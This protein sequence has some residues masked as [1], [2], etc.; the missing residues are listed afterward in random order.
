MLA[1]ALIAL[2]CALAVPALAAAET[3]VVNSAAD[4]EDAA[5]GDEYCKDAD[6]ECTLRAAI[7]E[8]NALGG[9]SAFEFSEAVFNGGPGATISLG[10]SLPTI[11]VT[12]T[13]DGECSVAEELQPCVG[14]DGPS[15]SNPALV[16]KGVEATIIGLAITG[17]KVGIE[18]TGGSKFTARQDWFG[19]KLDGSPGPNGTG[20]LLGPGLDGGRIGNEGVTNVFANST[21]DGLDIHG[22]SNVRVMSGY[23][24]VGPD[25]TAPAPNAGK[26]IEV[27]SFEGVEAIGN[28]IGTQ[29]EAREAASAKCDGGC[30]VISLA[31]KSGIDLEGDGGEEFPAVSTSIV[32]NYVGLDATGAVAIPNADDNVR[33][34]SA[35]RTTIGG[36]RAGEANYFAGGDAAVHA[37]PAASS[38][39]VRGNSVGL[40]AAGG[41]VPPPDAGIV[42]DSTQVPD[43]AAEPMVVENAL[44]MQGGIGISQT[45]FAGWIAYNWIADAATGIRVDGEGE[46]GRGNLIEGNA[47]EGSALNGILIEGN[48]NEVFGNE[49]VASGDAGIAVAGGALFSGFGISGNRIG[50]DTEADENFI[51]GS[52]GA[53]IEI[54]NPEIATNQVARNRGHGNAGLFIDLV[55]VSPATEPKGPNEGIKPPTFFATTTTE[56]VGGDADAGARIRVFRKARAEAGELASFLGEA[57]ADEEGEWEVTYDTPIPDGTIVTATQTSPVGGTSELVRTTAV[58]V[59]VAAS[60]SCALPGGCAPAVPAPPIPRTKLF[61]GTKGKKFSGA[62]VVFKFKA[63]V[64]GSSFQCRLDGGAFGRCHSPKVYT[65]LK[66]GKHRFEVRATNSAGQADPTPAKLKFTVLG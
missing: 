28:R 47:I 40:D 14:V 57:I 2:A 19:I 24:G 7:E 20:M 43:P 45:G 52:G 50:G 29:V 63:S 41:D 44:R 11:E 6:E 4:T 55:A 36:P 35:V 64:D 8:A 26:D 30:N 25:G 39:V 18:V 62:T 9:E 56:A 58:A 1:G 37:G 27:T 12:I 51:A 13:I 38:L 59:P 23:F 15:L 16:T 42:V 31:G 61:K 46:Q 21:E 48:D 17:A 66:P 3:F 49:V 54:V 22:A 60:K 33:V 32:G 5:P 10:S 65:G 34:G 53:A